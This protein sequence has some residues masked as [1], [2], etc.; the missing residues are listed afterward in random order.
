M[1]VAAW[2]TRWDRRLA[3]ELVTLSSDIGSAGISSQL[4]RTLAR[5]SRVRVP[6]ARVPA[7]LPVSC[8][9]VQYYGP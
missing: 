8:T 9:V 4:S 2:D 5:V 3:G 7:T 6:R 1:S